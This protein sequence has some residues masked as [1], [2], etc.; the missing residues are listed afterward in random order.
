MF[1]TIQATVLQKNN[2][3]FVCDPC[4]GYGKIYQFQ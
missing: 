4:G 1:S 3:A 2:E